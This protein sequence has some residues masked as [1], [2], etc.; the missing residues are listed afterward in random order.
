MTPQPNG[1]K[2][3][4]ENRPQ[5]SLM[6]IFTGLFIA[7]ALI[8]I[9][10]A[11][12]GDPARAWQAYLLNFLFFSAIAQGAVLFS[13]LM[14][15]VKARW[16]GPLADIGEAFAAFF[17]VSLV[18]FLIL[19][20]G[21]QYVFPWMHADLHGK[22]V[23][24]NVPF[25]FG[26]DFIGLCLLYG[27]GI[28]FLYHRLYFTLKERG[29][30]GPL[31]RRLLKRWEGKAFD[32]RKFAARTTTFAILYLLAFAL[33]LSLIGYD[34]VMAADPHWYS[35]L[36]GAYSFIKAVYIGFGALIVLSARLHLSEKKRLPRGGEPVSRHRQ[37][38]LRLLSGVGRFLLRPIRGHLVRQHSRRDQLHHRTHHATPWNAL[39]WTVF[40]GCFVAP[41][42]I[43]I[44]RRIKTNPQ[45]MTVICLA[46]MLGIWLEHYLLLGP[47]FHPHVHHLPLGW[48]EV[49]VGVGF[50][51]LLAIAVTRYLKT[52]PELLAAGAENR[53]TVEAH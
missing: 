43:L 28:V 41:F 13:A 50:F 17:P 12:I 51:G 18:L 52:F 8:F 42:I 22:E 40:I 38:L 10:V 7:G 23:W 34:L 19:F 3:M 49:A 4:S 37:A 20:L 35:T 26:R 9:A 31:G 5:P 1:E 53:L 6:K 33:V 24:L 48:V 25:L 36:F 32:E 16:S 2:T 30:S 44:N 27:I 39:A 46:V 45:A 29:A 14:H 15:T 21:R 47:A 11:I